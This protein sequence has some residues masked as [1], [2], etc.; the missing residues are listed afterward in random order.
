MNV[1]NELLEKAAIQGYLAIE[2]VLEALGTVDEEESLD[3][4][5]GELRAA[6]IEIETVEDVAE[7]ADD[8]EESGEE[9]EEGPSLDE[10]VDEEV[11]AWDGDMY[12]LDGIGVDDTVALY[13]REMARVPL[14]SNDEEVTLARKIEEGRAA[15]VALQNNGHHSA[16]ERACLE[17]VLHAG[18][19]ARDHLIRANTR[20]V[21]SI[22]K[23]YIGR[24]V[25]FLDLIQEGNLGLMKAV[26]KFEY[27]RGYRFSTYATWWIRQTIT[28]AIADQGRTIRVPVHMSDRIRRLY[29]RAQEIEQERGTRPT[30]E[31]L[32]E[33]MGLEPRKVQWMMRVSWQP[34]SLERPVGE[35]E[36]SELSNFIEDEHTPT[37]PDTAYQGMLRDRIE[38][39]L[40]TLSPREVR[41]LRMRFGLYN[42]RSYTL[43]EVGQ[44]FGLTRERIRQIEGQA[45]R[46]LRHP[47][48]SR[49]LKDYL[50]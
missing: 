1:V 27:Q 46:R 11:E 4:V 31:E 36:D 7:E 15:K 28:R 21:V 13:L 2:D 49:D 29:R 34:L 26:E 14:L 6:G 19:D 3:T 41:I 9:D 40:T 5:L 33:E 35:D 8:E 24:G 48:R 43:E 38:E 17:E 45:L 22:A 18:I 20:L 50:R 39:V 25:P 30:P 47:S 12:G 44:K 42:G 23:K 10:I 32:A 37:P 16:D